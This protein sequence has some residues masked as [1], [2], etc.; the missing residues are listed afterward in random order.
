MNGVEDARFV[1]FHDDDQSTYYATYTA[2]NG[3]VMLPQLLETT[4]F[5]NF[6]ISTLN[7]PE[8]KNKGMALFPRKINDLYAMLSRQDGENIYLMFSENIQI[9]YGASDESICLAETTEEELL[10]Q[11]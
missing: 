10:D 8:V 6:K 4:D 9:Y 2:Y 3:E 1:H 5:L 11:I 7:G